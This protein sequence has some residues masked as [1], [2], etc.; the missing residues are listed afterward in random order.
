M[1]LSLKISCLI[2]LV[3]LLSFSQK[4]FTNSELEEL[5]PLQS[6]HNELPLNP[7]ASL[8]TKNYYKKNDRNYYHGGP[9]QDQWAPYLA[10]GNLDRP[11]SFPFLQA[12][13]GIGFLRFSGVSGSLSRSVFPN[14]LAR[15]SLIKG[16]FAYS[17]TPL[18]EVVLGSSVTDW[19]QIGLSYQHQGDID[20]QTKPQVVPV[21]PGT[22]LMVGQFSS[23]LRLDSI[24]AKVYFSTVKVLIFKSI[25]MNP[26]L[27][28]AV[29]AGWQ[30]WT[31]IR[32]DSLNFLPFTGGVT[33]TD[34]FSVKNKYS[35][36]CV[37]MVDMGIKSRCVIPSRSLAVSLG[38]KYN[39]WG[40][41][42]NIGL[43]SQQRNYPHNGGFDKRIAI[44]TIYQFAPYVG[45]QLDF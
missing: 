22:S 34:N 12:S 45:F 5:D 18:V 36:N 26:Y 44:K 3:T 39:Q 25:A 14:S 16:R 41:A 43:A 30:S 31:N 2:C 40:Q 42:R 21:V 11:Y 24:S 4:V 15:A 28:L 38:C 35:C 29:G 23:S 9:Y 20:I 1:K 33:S 37:F 8:I 19:F 6:I 10:P 7:N 27:G 13:V 17:R 32:V